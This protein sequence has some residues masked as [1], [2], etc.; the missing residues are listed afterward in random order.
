MRY[1]PLI[2]LALLVASCMKDE[3]PV[4]KHEAG[5][6]ISNA[7]NLGTDYRYQ[8]YYDFET[9]TFVHQHEK[10][11]WDLGFECD[12]LGFRIILNSAK[13]MAASHSNT[14]TF[15]SITDTT[16]SFWKYDVSSGNL[17]STAI[18]DWLTEGGVYV[19]DR[20]YSHDGIHQGFRKV[21][22]E[23]INSDSYQIHYAQ[24]D[25]SD[26]STHIIQ[27]D[28]NYNF[29]FFS[30]ETNS[31]VNIQPPKEDWDLVFGQY[32]HLFEPTFPYLVTGVLSNRNDVEVAEVFDK[33]F[34]EIE[35]E[36]VN[37][38]TF[39]SHIDIIGY[40]WKTF[41]GGTYATH[42]EKNY[43]VKTTEGLYYKIHFIDFYTSYGEKGNPVF[44]V[45]AL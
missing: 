7:V 30:F 21:E 22:F 9:N 13:A 31:V 37:A 28:S 16:G 32:S 35:F 18:G 25:G 4:P 3:I 10:I 2:L 45:S 8:A 11:A 44:E 33:D 23:Q 26:E 24:L 41:V 19:L 15:T 20:G 1:Y 39:S 34:S 5:E 27:K 36:D 38:Y 12:A 14:G 40:D 6:S 42:A 17:D 29:A 43:I